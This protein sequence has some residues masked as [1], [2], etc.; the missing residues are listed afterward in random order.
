MFQF[1]AFSQFLFAALLV[2][3]GISAEEASDGP[4]YGVDIVSSFMETS[5]CVF[6]SHRTLYVISRSAVVSHASQECL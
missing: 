4:I 3:P 6:T 2:L 1:T 5:L